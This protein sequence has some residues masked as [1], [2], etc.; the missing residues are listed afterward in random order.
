[1]DVETFLP[2]INKLKKYLKNST[3]YEIILLGVTIKQLIR[4]TKC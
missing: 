4:N 3:N 2:L 1:M